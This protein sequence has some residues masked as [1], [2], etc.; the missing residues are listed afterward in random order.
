MTDI[1]KKAELKQQA[2]KY[3]I[4][5]DLAFR[6]ASKEL[7]QKMLTLKKD[8]DNVLMEDSDVKEFIKTVIELGESES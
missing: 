4:S 2:L 1:E 7:K 3:K 5:Y 8:P 6:K